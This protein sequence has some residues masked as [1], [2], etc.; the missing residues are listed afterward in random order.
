M[1][2]LGTRL[3]IKAVDVGYGAG[4]QLVRRLPAGL[5]RSG[6]SFFADRA[7]ARRGEG[8]AQL[9]ANLARI[10]PRANDDELDGLVRDGMRSYAR[11]W[12]EAFRLPAMDHSTL[13]AEVAPHITGQEYLEAA[14]AEG[15]GVVTVLPHSGNFEVLGVWAVQRFGGLTT[16]A[17][18]LRPESVYQRFVAYRESLG[19]E[20]LPTTGGARLPAVVLA[21]R[22]RENK[23]IC[24]LG[25]RDLTR[26]G[27]PVT[28]FGEP[29]RMPAG[30]AKL[31]VT[32]G[33][34]LLPVGCWNTDDGWGFR[35]HPPVRVAGPDGVAAATQAVADVFAGD[36]A[37]HP[38]DWH[39]LQKLWLADLPQMTR[40]RLAR[41][42]S[43]RTNQ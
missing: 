10:V 6:F 11:Y 40:D 3:R 42:E 31:A 23:I 24:L 37:A 29:T 20:I 26:T 33:A 2:K 41:M 32:T 1:S 30:P 34:P 7:T 12:C 9:R 13:G 36:I 27:A 15:N 19:F 5:A 39:M 14:L 16:V 43:G 28:F 18:R 38:A 8:V 22:L 17:E 4:W 21:E 35:I 25:D